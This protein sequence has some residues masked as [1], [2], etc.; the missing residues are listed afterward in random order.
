L[1]ENEKVDARAKPASWRRKTGGK[2]VLLAMLPSFILILKYCELLRAVV[3]V[4]LRDSD[5]TK[6]RSV[7]ALTKEGR[8]ALPVEV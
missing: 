6:P 3:W 2:P 7:V 4:V 5:P 1:E 8:M